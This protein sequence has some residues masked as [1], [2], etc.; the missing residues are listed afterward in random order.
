MKTPVKR[1]VLWGGA[2]GAVFALLVA[3]FLLNRPNIAPEVTW[4]TLN[5][6]KMSTQDLRGKV[7][8][9][10][11]WATSCTT[12]V[13]EMP[14]L[15]KLHEQF[16]SRG[17]V[18]LATAMSYDRP[19]FIAN[20]TQTRAL[21]FY[22]AHDADNRIASAFFNTQVTPTSFVLDKHGNVVKRYVGQPPEKE[23]I[24]LIERLLQ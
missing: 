23:L 13:K 5:G 20:F 9:V 14:L 24:A 22:V 3:V 12:C 4:T 6:T 8:L 1:R 21:P 2:A 10:N 7:V 17:Y 19:E 11:F 18:T 15:T 16:A